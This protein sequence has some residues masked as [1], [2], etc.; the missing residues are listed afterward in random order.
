M[1]IGDKYKHVQVFVVSIF[2]IKKLFIYPNYYL[3]YFLFIYDGY[4]FLFFY[5]YIIFIFHEIKNFL[6]SLT[7]QLAN[8][9]DYVGLVNKIII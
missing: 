6:L 9:N 3:S 4:Y 5:F 1:I 8:H 7:N 2:R